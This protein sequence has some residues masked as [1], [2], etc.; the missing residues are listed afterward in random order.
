MLVRYEPA[1]RLRSSSSAWQRKQ[2]VFSWQTELSR[3]ITGA[4]CKFSQ[5]RRCGSVLA[6][7]YSFLWGQHWCEYQKCSTHHR[8][9]AFTEG[10]S[11]VFMDGTYLRLRLSAFI[12]DGSSRWV[13]GAKAG[14]W[15]AEGEELRRRLKVKRKQCAFS[16]FFTAALNSRFFLCLWDVWLC[17]LCGRRA[18]IPPVSVPCENDISI[19]NNLLISVQLWHSITMGDWQRNLSSGS[20]WRSSRL[21]LIR[22]N[23]QRCNAAEDPIK[24]WRYGI[25]WEDRWVKEQISWKRR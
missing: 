14:T 12:G 4:I 7:I 3:Q 10:D 19:S 17:S 24:S 15:P 6:Q 5:W 23:S 1:R 11:G 18:C 20:H 13:T 16:G 22:M 25:Y 9:S 21:C 2:F 8:S